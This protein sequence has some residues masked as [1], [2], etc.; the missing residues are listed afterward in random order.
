[1][2][3]ELITEENLDDYTDNGEFPNFVHYPM[4][5]LRE[6][7]YDVKKKDTLIFWGAEG[8]NIKSK[9]V[10]LKSIGK[11]DGTLE[12]VLDVLKSSLPPS[13]VMLV[14]TERGEIYRAIVPR[15][16]SR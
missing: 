8:H 14:H 7:F 6:D 12:E 9:N 3:F 10:A 2:R 13:Q 5:K 4:K 16:R 1:M 15:R 11:F